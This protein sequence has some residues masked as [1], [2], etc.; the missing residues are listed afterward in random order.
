MTEP[1]TSRHNPRIKLAAKLRDR[2]GRHEQ[3]RIIID[4][5]REIGRALDAGVEFIEAFVCES[6][7]TNDGQALQ[8][9][10]AE[11]GCEIVLVNQ[12]VLEKIAFG[13]RSDGIVAIAKPPRADLNGLTIEA[14]ML[15]AVLENV[16]KPGNV[17][18]VLR[19]ADAAGVSAVIVADAGTDLYNPNS[20]RASAGTIFSMPLVACSGDEALSWL[21]QHAFQIVTTRVDGAVDYTTVNYSGRSAVVLGSEAEGLSSIWQGE[22]V[23]SVQLPMRGI[24]DSLNVS[25]TAAV[26][27]YEALRQ[28]PTRS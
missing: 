15:V 7:V 14:E 17:G 10:L 12:S 8:R 5:L 18:A 19:S 4:G 9:R 24:G 22:D 25:V 21:R 28:R 23:P 6:I 2:R 27:F 1:I 3:Q 26:L 16:E 11:S 20:I 13:D